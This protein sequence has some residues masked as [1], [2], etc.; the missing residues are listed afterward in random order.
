MTESGRRLLS[1]GL[2][3]G[4]VVGLAM[5]NVQAGVAVA[6][7]GL[8]WAMLQTPGLPPVLA[9][10]LTFQWTQ[11]TVGLYYSWLTGRP[12]ETMVLS[13]Y[14]TMIWIGLACV[15]VLTLGVATG[16]RIFPAQYDQ[17]PHA[18]LG[19][20]WLLL[21]A[22]YGGLT[23]AEG[24]LNR[25]AW[26]NPG[27]TQGILAL[28][29]IR[30]GALYLM[31]RRCARPEIRWVP[32]MSLL[33]LEV[34]LGLTGYFAGFREP[35]Y[36]AA[37]VLLE[38]IDRRRVKHWFALG[39]IVIMATTT[40]V[41]W[42]GIRDVYRSEFQAGEIY[43]VSREVR[44]S[45]LGE[46]ASGWYSQ[47]DPTFYY[48]LDALV[49]R[50]WAIYYP[51]LAVQRVPGAVPHTD[52]AL[53]SAALQHVLLPRVLFPDKPVIPSDSEKVRTYS[54]VWVAGRDEGT[55]I[56]FGYAAE[57]YVDFGVPLMFAPIFVFGV[58]MGIAFNALVRWFHFEEIAVPVLVVVFWLALYP[59]ERSWHN[60]LGY[61]GTLLLY[62]GGLGLLVDRVLWNRRAL[63]RQERDVYVM[64]PMAP[65]PQGPPTAAPR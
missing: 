5:G 46:L 11:V 9:L 29:L 15:V 13:D 43:D 53:L 26:D 42:I 65:T 21:A 30:L 59:F 60:M 17:L 36:L 39:A 27:L 10:A 22:T 25:L 33:G 20:S 32:L 63:E 41:L 62:L 14:V 38:S 47:K 24:P 57:S 56:A 37:A 50:V 49:D 7:L 45:R 54:G 58:L 12:M 18:E 28:S 1:I 6:V 23:L 40:S 48:D 55:S 2:A 8:I 3:A 51:A 16:R 64:P 52:G 19:A 4:V 34:V 35:L 44:L 61:G 31:M